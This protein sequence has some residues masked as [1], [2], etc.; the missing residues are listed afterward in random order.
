[1]QSSGDEMDN[2]TEGGVLIGGEHDFHG[3]KL[4]SPTYIL[5]DGY[6]KSNWVP[7]GTIEHLK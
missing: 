4:D 1:M 7:V 2:E 5:I 6:F 3:A